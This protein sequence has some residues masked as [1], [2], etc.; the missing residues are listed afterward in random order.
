MTEE[1]LTFQDAYEHLADV[2]NLVSKAHDRSKRNMQRAITEAYRRLPELYS[3]RYYVRETMVATTGTYSTGTIA[4]SSS[5]GVVTLT[6]GTWPADAE[7][8][9][10][11][12]DNVLYRVSRRLTDTTLELDTNIRPPE[13]IAAG[14]SYEIARFRYLLPVDVGDV[15]RVINGDL[16]LV[17]SRSTPDELFWLNV[18]QNTES[19]PTS[20]CV[21]RSE[22]YPGRWELW[23]SSSDTTRRELTIQY[24]ARHSSL[25]IL[26]ENDGSVAVSSDAD[27]ATFTDGPTLTE[28][29][30]GCVLRIGSDGETP[31]PR[32]GSYL[33]GPIGHVTRLPAYERVVTQVT[34]GTTAV[35]NRPIPEDLSSGRGYTLSSHI[36]VNPSGMWELF[37]RLCEQQYDIITRADPSKLQQSRT[38]AMESQRLAQIAD[39][40]MIP[41]HERPYGVSPR[42]IEDW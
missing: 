41:V 8:S 29:Y 5:T 17:L 25:G 35:L 34:N 3:W 6:G 13:D 14:T 36:D 33:S 7:F 12:I 22:D 9:S 16:D 42:V 31:T 4:Y 32:V 26:T 39:G 24:D 10:V 20:Y 2:F 38:A 18:A 15:R 21:A 28:D 27:V 1:L 40:K 19:Y 11:I 30:V 23:L 37:M